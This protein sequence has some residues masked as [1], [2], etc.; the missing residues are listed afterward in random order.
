MDGSQLDVLTGW[1]E[2]CGLDVTDVLETRGYVRLENRATGLCLVLEEESEGFRVAAQ[3]PY[4][5]FQ[6]QLQQLVDQGD[7]ERLKLALLEL[8]LP[9]ECT[10]CGSKF[11]Y[12]NVLLTHCGITRYY[13]EIKRP[14]RPLQAGDV[15]IQFTDSR[16]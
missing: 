8:R 1:A 10:Y 4:Q 2:E 6:E 11:P 16:K 7:V 9:Q 12:G 14:R 3:R 5:E 13:A 15:K